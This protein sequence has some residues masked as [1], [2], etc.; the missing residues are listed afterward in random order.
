MRTIFRQ[1]FKHFAG[2]NMEAL[3]LSAPSSTLR[4]TRSAVPEHHDD[5]VEALSILGR[6][7]GRRCESGAV[8]LGIRL[9]KPLHS[10]SIAAYG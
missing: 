2:D 7:H 3:A 10:K 8:L 1:N 5:Y 9:R 4:R 6:S